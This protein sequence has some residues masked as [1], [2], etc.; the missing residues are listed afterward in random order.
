MGAQ[1]TNSEGQNYD[2]KASTNEAPV[3][4]VVLAPFYIAKYEVTGELYDAV[5]AKSSSFGAN[6]PIYITGFGSSATTIFPSTLNTFL[7]TLNSLTG[8]KFD[9][10]TEEEWEYTARGGKQTH[11][12]IYAG[13][14]TIGDVANKSNSSIFTVGSFLANELG[15]YDMTG[16]VSEL[17]YYRGDYTNE[18]QVN[19]KV[20]STYYCRGSDSHG[21]YMNS[22]YGRVTG[23]YSS[24]YLGLRLILRITQ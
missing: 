14:N 11:Y 6:Y 3:H 12:Y 2:S 15:I 23:R 13:S 1:K 9:I 19:P 16:N 24:Y 21:I 20:T 7:T 10:P 22:T 8:L 18:L 4:Q 17:C 5:M